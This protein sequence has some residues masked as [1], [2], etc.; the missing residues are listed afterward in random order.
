MVSIGKKLIRE[1][2]GSTIVLMGFALLLLLTVVG[3]VIDGGTMYAA[4][5]HMQKVANAAALSGAQELTGQQSAV[6]NVVNDILLKHHEEDSL[7]ATDIQLKSNVQVSLEK[8][9]QLGFSRL[10]GKENVV[11]KV[12]AKAQILP[13]GIASGAAPLGIDESIP[14]EYN[15]PYKLKVDS[16]GVEA[17]YFGILALGG[18]G[19]NTY[20]SNLKY[21]YQNEIKI[22]DIIDTQT[23][24]I[25]G[26][27]R[28]GVQLRIDSDPYPPGDYS[29]RDSPR[30]ILIPVYQPYDQTSNQLK[31]I[32]VTGFAYFYIAEPMSSKDT[33]ITGMF[34]E[35]TGTGYTTPGTVDKG[36][37]AIRLVE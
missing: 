25:A 32:K 31:H 34:I 20:E 1:Q 7:V 8:Q 22:G 33:S 10:L 26:K 12:K 19:A 9:V 36:A 6:E 35:R 3:L 11:V 18:P 17:G 13:M 5:S 14:L 30:I 4:K 37:Y 29:H 16:S 23:G 28:D 27:T 24:N 21:G 15:K 2:Q